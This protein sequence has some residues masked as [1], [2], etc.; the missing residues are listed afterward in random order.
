MKIRVNKV[1]LKELVKIPNSER[2]KVEKLLFIE[3]ENYKEIR[4]IPNISKLKGHSGYFK[5]RFGDYRIGLKYDKDTLIFE[6]VMHRKDIY[7]FFP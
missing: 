2:I 1:F 5:I 4:Q 7:R 3:V 6:R